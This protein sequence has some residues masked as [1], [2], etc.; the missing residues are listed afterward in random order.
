[1]KKK[2]RFT[3]NKKAWLFVLPSVVLIV[4]FVF[5]PMVQAFF[6]SFK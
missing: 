4:A 3:V 2:V 5:Y 1:M 6:Y